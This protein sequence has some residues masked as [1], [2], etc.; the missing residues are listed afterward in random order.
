MDAETKD[1]MT[2][3]NELADAGRVIVRAAMERDPSVSVKADASYVT[4]TDLAVETRLREMI[5]AKF[6][7][8]GVLGE[9]HGSRDLDAAHVWVLDPIDGT[10]AFV[11]GLP[12]F[13]TLIGLAREGR[14]YLGIVDHPATDERWTGVS[15]T[16]AA[17]NG[18]AIRTRPCEALAHAYMTNS[19][20][21][22]LKPDE[23]RRFHA[24][25]G[26]AQYTQYGGSCYSYGLLASGR[27]DIGI[28]AALDT[29]DIFAPTAVIE[30]AGGAVTDWDGRPIGFDMDG[31]VLATGSTTI[32]RQALAVLADGAGFEAAP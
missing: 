17:H 3:A 29:F 14:P 25:R 23:A 5:D 19:N 26:Q 18:R 24:L 13:G 22:F 8:H 28:D 12:V 7:N 9:E 31:R 32:H 6:P 15:G 16:S 2:F 4:E 27:T 1:L 10:A 21:D 30:G 20:P 11:A